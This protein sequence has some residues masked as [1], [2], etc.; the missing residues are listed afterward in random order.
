MVPSLPF[1]D[2]SFERAFASNLYGHLPPDDRAHLLAEM[3]RVSAELVILD[4]LAASGPFREGP[5]ERSLRNGTRLVIHK[6]YFTVDRLLEEIHGAEVVM[7]GPVFA[8]LRLR[9]GSG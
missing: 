9:R 4:Q 2:D 8:V 1:V 7:N 5:E 6:C 3:A